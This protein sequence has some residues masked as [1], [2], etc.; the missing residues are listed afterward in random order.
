M[1]E[2]HNEEPPADNKP[3]RRWF[4]VSLRTLFAV[5]GV[6]AVGFGW[7]KRQIEDERFLT[8]A[9]TFAEDLKQHQWRAS[10]HLDCDTNTVEQW[11]HLTILGGDLVVS[12]G[13]GE[14][15]KLRRPTKET[16]REVVALLKDEHFAVRCNAAKTLAL[17]GEAFSAAT[18]NTEEI[19]R[20]DLMSQEAFPLL[21]PLLA[22]SNAEVRQ[23]AALAVGQLSMHQ[24]AIPTLV[25]SLKREDDNTA[26]VYI[27]WAIQRVRCRSLYH[28]PETY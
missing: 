6:A 26:R 9:L 2:K 16:F 13:W 8:A 10:D 18:L 27:L 14:N 20:R 4:Q 15:H 21:L 12:K 24:T 23:A 5:L 22:D 1:D 28:W 7:W 19:E 17:Y 25:A 11:L 3:R